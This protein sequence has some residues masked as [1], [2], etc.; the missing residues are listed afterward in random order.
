MNYDVWRF[1][2]MVGQM[3]F[4]ISVGL[5]LWIIARDRV[6]NK[7]ITDLESRIGKRCEAHHARTAALE[8]TTTAMPSKGEMDALSNKI[9]RLNEKL[10]RLD[11]RLTGVNRA[12]DLLNQHHLMGE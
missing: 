3:V 6:T 10:A 2:I 4:N 5:Y 12:V 8:I 1:W 11:G 9:D 7:R